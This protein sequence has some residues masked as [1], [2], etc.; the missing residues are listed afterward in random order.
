MLLLLA[1]RNVKIISDEKHAIFEHEM[2]SSQML[3]VG[4]SN[5]YFELQK[6]VI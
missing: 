3:T 5:V 1:E 4:Y 6:I 2:Q